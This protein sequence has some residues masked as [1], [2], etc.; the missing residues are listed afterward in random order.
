[1]AIQPAPAPQTPPSAQYGPHR[2]ATLR[3][4][5]ALMLREMSTT[6]GRTPG[7]YAWAILEPLGAIL[8]L[9]LGFSL[10]IR[11]PQL[12]T[13]FILFYATGY[14]PFSLYQ[15]LS[16]KISKSIAFSKP[17]LQYPAVSWLDAVLARFLL[18][19]LTGVTVACL[20]LSGILAVL[21]HQSVLDLTPVIEAMSM[22][23]L[24]GLAVGTLNCVLVGLFPIW[25]ITWSILT[26]PLFIASGIF[27]LY[28]GMPPLAQDI[29]WYNPLLHIIGLMRSGFY[30]TYP[31]T[32]VS[33]LYVLGVSLA[34]LTLGLILMGRYHRDILN[35]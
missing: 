2:F 8:V 4:T 29:L 31:A 9:S 16:N 3:T 7:G 19:A 17:L 15:S 1:M 32:Y 24:L 34:L 26:R 18:N 23:I 10:V 33:H 13:S 21:A 35:R 30:P 6:Y 25:E 5:L 28:E 11:T 27:F 20:L 22:A 14:M 12:G